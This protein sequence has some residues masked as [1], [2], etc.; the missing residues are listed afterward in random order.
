[1]AVTSIKYNEGAKKK[2]L[3]YKGV[4]ISYGDGMKK[5]KVFNSGDFVKDWYDHNKFIILKLSETEF[6]F[7]SSSTV[8]HFIMDGAPYDSAYLITGDDT[9]PYLKYDRGT[10]LMM[11]LGEEEGIEFFVKKGTKPTWEELKVL[12]GD[13]K[14]KTTKKNEKV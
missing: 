1:M 2:N 14:K 10:K 11:R 4:E 12:C 5:K 13:V 8:N 6:H 7:S 3:G 9:P